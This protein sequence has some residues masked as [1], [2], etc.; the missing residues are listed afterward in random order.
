MKSDQILAVTKMQHFIE[1][2]LNKPISLFELSRIAG[3]SP[4]HSAKLFKAYTGK[5]PFEYIRALRLSKAALV[6]RDQPCKVID[7]AFDFVFDSHEGFTRA[8]TREFGINPKTYIKKRSPLKL[9][10]PYPV[11]DYQFHKSKGEMTMDNKT[12]ITVFTQ[13]IEK[14]QRKLILKRGIKADEYFSYCDE[15]GC[16]I[17]GILSSIAD[18]LYE[19]M[20]LWL[21]V[22]IRAPGTSEYVQG[23]EVASDFN[24][25]IPEGFEIIDLKPEKIMIFQGPTYDDSVFEEAISDMIEAIKKFDPTLSGFKW[26]TESPRFQL[27]PQGYRGYIEGLPVLNNK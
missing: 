13:V 25:E 12:I 8:F 15:V 14:P 26:N 19:P 10:L 22:N 3:Y 11:S 9:F 24:G 23:V 16:D 5:A 7:V 20:G 6:F 18:A 17:W 4:C 2:N 21:P 27:E 1:N